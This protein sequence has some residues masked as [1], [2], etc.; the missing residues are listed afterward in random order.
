MNFVSSQVKMKEQKYKK[1]KT[2]NSK[3]KMEKGKKTQTTEG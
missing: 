1:L 3:Y 2:E